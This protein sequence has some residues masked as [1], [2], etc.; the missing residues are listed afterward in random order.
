LADNPT[1]A[2]YHCTYARM[3]I[4][5]K[6]VYSLTVNEAEKDALVGLLNEC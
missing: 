5:V 2:G 3:W 6:S 4:K 1:L